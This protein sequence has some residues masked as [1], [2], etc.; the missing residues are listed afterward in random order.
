MERLTFEGNF[1]EIARCGYPTCPYK[2]GCSQKQVW[3]RLKQY[4]DSKLSPED[5]ANLHA[6]LRLGDGMTLMRL[7]E[8]VVADQGGRV[9]IF[10]CKG[11]LDIVFGDQ[12]LFWGIDTDY[13]EEPIMEISVDDGRRISWYDGY[14]TVYLI[15]YDENGFR[16]EFSLDQI[17]KTVFLTREEAEKALAETEGKA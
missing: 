4:E 8:L 14:D 3:E 15:G 9:E 11:W 6:I 7:R 10:P 16:W 2:D 5:A 17:G 13:I 12:V 1:C